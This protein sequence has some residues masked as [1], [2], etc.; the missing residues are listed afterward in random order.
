MTV[1][2]LFLFDVEVFWH[3]MIEMNQQNTQAEP[4]PIFFIGDHLSP[5]LV[6]LQMLT[7]GKPFFCKK[8]TKRRGK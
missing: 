8:K 1:I 4:A 3:Q 5:I 6:F 2:C 7:R